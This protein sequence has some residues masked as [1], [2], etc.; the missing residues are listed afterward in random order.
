MRKKQKQENLYLFSFAADTYLIGSIEKKIS[1]IFSMRKMQKQENHMLQR[2][3]SEIQA[4]FFI[5]YNGF[6]GALV[7]N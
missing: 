6:S 1:G 7:V 2:G 4:G 5:Q 3:L